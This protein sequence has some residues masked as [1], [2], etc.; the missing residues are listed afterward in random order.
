M[1]AKT[2]FLGTGWDH[3][4]RLDGQG[5]IREAVEEQAVQRSIRLILGTAKGERVMRPDFGSDLSDLLFHP[6]N[7]VTQARVATAV[8]SALMRWE[9]RI[10]LLDIRVEPDGREP[11]LLIDIQYQLRSSNVRANLVYPF[12]I[13]GTSS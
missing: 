12:Y 10:K 11:V 9:P 6:I 8:K 3:P 5:R 1:A 2:S 7:R 13:Q 4:V